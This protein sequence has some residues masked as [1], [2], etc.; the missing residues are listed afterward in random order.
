MGYVLQVGSYV[1]WFPLMILTINAILRAGVRRY[2]LIFTY[3]VITLLIGVIQAPTALAYHR[4]FR[5]G[6]WLVFV[7]SAGE[8]AAYALLLLV[9]FSLIYQATAR[10]GARRLMRAILTA[11]PLLVIFASFL[12][13][14]DG[15]L[16]LGIWVTPWIRDLK[17]CAA[18]LDMALWTLLLLTRN[19][20]PRL[21]LLTG[22]MGVMFAGNAI[23]ESVQHLAN[24][25][26]SNTLFLVGSSLSV[27]ADLAFLYIWWRSFREGKRVQGAAVG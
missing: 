13:H 15:Q 17:F 27:V 9:V 1:L 7:R 3:I 8:V 25:N 22:G 26:G 6:E 20:D 2:P 4:S 14:Y 16:R 24:R 18:I 12:V 21:L 5:Q 11:V 19:R 23:G 10:F